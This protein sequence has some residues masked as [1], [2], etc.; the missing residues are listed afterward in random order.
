[1]QEAADSAKPFVLR[2]EKI[3][4]SRCQQVQAI[5]Q[6]RDQPPF[7]TLFGIIAAEFG[8]GDQQGIGQAINRNRLR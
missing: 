7:G 6:H 4:I 5:K 3:D 1:M 2:L 8:G